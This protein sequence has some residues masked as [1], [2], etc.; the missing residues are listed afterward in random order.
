VKTILDYSAEGGETETDFQY[1]FHQILETIEQAKKSVH[2]PFAVFKMTGIARLGLLE[3][4]SNNES[5]NP[6]ELKEL[7]RVKDRVNTL[8]QAAFEAG[9]PLMI[10][11]EETWIQQ[12][13]DNMVLEMMRT[14]NREKA[15]V[16]NTLQMYRTDRLNWFENLIKTAQQEGFYPGIKLVRGAYIEKER[17]RAEEMNYPSP[18]FETKS[19]TDQ[20][21]DDAVSLGLQNHNLVW[22]CIATHNEQSC[23]KAA[24]QMKFLEIEQGDT[25]VY[26][27]Q[28]LGMSDHISFNLA[29]E[30]FNIAKYMPYGPVKRVIPYLIR[31]AEEN[32]SVG[33][34][35][36]R[37]LSLI[38]SE[39]QRRAGL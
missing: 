5:L 18:V 21:F 11:A 28:L 20:A 35:T 25:K 19:Q 9:I 10:D 33:G 26:F 27:S 6:L 7:Q 13:I 17:I 32:T 15:I 12:A 38:I 34:Q 36:S 23:L 39:K 16:F 1:T 31:R 29:K 24:E 2:I 22:L 3:K 30:G 37:E 8:C 4:M 14:Y